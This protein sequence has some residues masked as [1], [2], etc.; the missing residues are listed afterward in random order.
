MSNIHTCRK[1]GNVAN[2]S[3]LLVFVTFVSVSSI[4]NA[5]QAREVSCSCTKRTGSHNVVTISAECK[6]GTS[7]TDCCT[8]AAKAWPAIKS[9]KPAAQSAASDL[10]ASSSG[11]IPICSGQGS[12]QSGQCVSMTQCAGRST[13]QE[14][15]AGLSCCQAGKK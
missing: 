6:S 5:V 10:G 1:M 8:K 9:C 14:T 7:K 13:I 11:C 15:N 4:D 2:L 3:L 12:F